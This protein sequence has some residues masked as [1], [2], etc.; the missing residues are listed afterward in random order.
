MSSVVYSSSKQ[1]IKIRLEY[2]PKEGYFYTNMEKAEKV[3]EIC[4]EPFVREKENVKKKL[5]SS[6][7]K[8]VSE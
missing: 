4:A 5:Q 8:C 1:V 3:M 7:G 6:A 2:P